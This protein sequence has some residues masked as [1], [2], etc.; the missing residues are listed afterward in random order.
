VSR[1]IKCLACECVVFLGPKWYQT[2]EDYVDGPRPDVT[3]EDGRRPLIATSNGRAHHGTVQDWVYS[4]TRPCEWG[5]CPHDKDPETCEAAVNK[6][7]ASKCPSSRG[8][9]AVRRGAITSHL[10][11]DVPPEVVSERMDVSLQVLYRHYDV[12]TD[13]ERM[14]QRREYL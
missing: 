1:R 9:H 10:L 3:D 11:D 12:R 2:L 6:S 14:S 13:R 5:E 8:P 7:T 4:A